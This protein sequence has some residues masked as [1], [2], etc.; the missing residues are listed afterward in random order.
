VIVKYAVVSP[1]P[2]PREQQY[3]RR[4]RLPMRDYLLEVQFDPQATP[5][6]VV[7]F[8]DGR[9]QPIALDEDRRAH[10][11]H[12]DTSPGTTGI[13]WSWPAS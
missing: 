13:R 10:L 4:L 1:D 11:V 3:T 8:G 2:G 6:S 9:T 7:A 12:T 5:A